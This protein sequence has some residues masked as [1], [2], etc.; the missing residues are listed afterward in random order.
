M[1]WMIARSMPLSQTV[2]RSAPRVFALAFIPSLASFVLVLLAAAAMT[3]TPRPGQEG[4]LLPSALFL[5][6]AFVAVHI[7]YLW[8]V[9]RTIRRNGS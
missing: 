4:M 9:E 3:L 8:L 2:T 5:G 7:L 1:Q 6:G